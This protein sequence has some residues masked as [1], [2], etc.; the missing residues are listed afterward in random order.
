MLEIPHNFAVEPID[1]PRTAH[2]DQGNFARL[3][4]FKSDSR[5]S[6]NIKAIA[7]SDFA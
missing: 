4:R 6:R 5:P 3:T 2:G 7:A 1:T